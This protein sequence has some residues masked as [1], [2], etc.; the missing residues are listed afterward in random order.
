M[1]GSY[2]QVNNTV[3]GVGFF[4]LFCFDFKILF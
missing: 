3:V 2:P 4:V 1:D